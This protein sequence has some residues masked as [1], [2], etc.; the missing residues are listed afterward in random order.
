MR[1]PR[2]GLEAPGPADC[3]LGSGREGL[4]GET[5]R[6]AGFHSKSDRGALF[7]RFNSGESFTVFCGGTASQFVKHAIEVGEGLEANGVSDFA[8]THIRIQEQVLGLFD[9]DA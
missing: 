5:K 7:G 6:D 8:D 9:A 4:R 2:L 1:C 3:G